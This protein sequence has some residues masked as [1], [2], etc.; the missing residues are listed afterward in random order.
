ME[1]L[2][3]F[4]NH[5][6]CLLHFCSYLFGYIVPAVINKNFFY[7]QSVWVLL[8]FWIFVTLKFYISSQ[9]IV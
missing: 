4:L 7:F 9:V 5:I 1:T 6:Y 8:Y 2:Y 3:E